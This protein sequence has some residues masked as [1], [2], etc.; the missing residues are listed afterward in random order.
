MSTVELD[1]VN[2]NNRDNRLENLRFLC[3]NCHSQTDTYKGKNIN[4]GKIKVSDD[5]LLT[6]YKKCGNIHKA[7]IEV[8][9]AAK[10]GNYSRLKKLIAGVV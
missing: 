7:L 3:P 9:L 8:G 2:G 4:T 10:G 5:E 6:A 1:H